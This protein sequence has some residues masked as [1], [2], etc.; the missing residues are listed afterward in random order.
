M[1]EVTLT[2]RFG[3]PAEAAAALTRL[4]TPGVIACEDRPDVGAPEAQMSL[5]LVPTAVHP[6]AVAIA[7]NDPAAVFGIVALAS[8]GPAPSVPAAPPS[9][10]PFTAVVAPSA[11]APE[12]PTPGLPPAPPA[13][14]PAAPAP[15]PSAPAPTAP[16]APTNPAVTERDTRNLPW[17]KRIHSETK[18]KNADGT[19]RKKRGTAD[20]FMQQVER[21]LLGAVTAPA[22]PPLPAGADAGALPTTFEAATSLFAPHMMSGKI[23]NLAMASALGKVMLANWGQLKDRPDLIP[24]VAA[25]LMPLIAA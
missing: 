14:L 9:H 22:A 1:P 12:A 6:S 3:T 18:A 20:T 23:T 13:P 4:A 25:E 21:E 16:V 19:W 15:V 10:A 11:T 7:D 8:A 24:T 17:D 2:L 5:P